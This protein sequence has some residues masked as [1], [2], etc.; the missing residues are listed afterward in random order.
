[1]PNAHPYTQKE[2]RMFS[3]NFKLDPESPTSIYLSNIHPLRES[4]TEEG[5]QK[6]QFCTP[7]DYCRF[8]R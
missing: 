4:S 1:M 5:H 8:L 2:K 6:F 3:W 7:G